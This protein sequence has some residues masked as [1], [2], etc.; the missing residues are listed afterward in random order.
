MTGAV[1]EGEGK[2]ISA[3][4][5]LHRELKRHVEG[6]RRH[7]SPSLR[8][9]AELRRAREGLFDGSPASSRLLALLEASAPMRDRAAMPQ[10]ELDDLMLVAWLV[11]WHRPQVGRDEK[12]QAGF[13]NDL[14]V[15]RS[16]PS[17]PME[18]RAGRRP[19]A[20]DQR[21]DR[22]LS[23]R[24]EDLP[25]EL[26]RLF[27]LLAKAG[28]GG[29]PARVD[30]A[31]LVRDLGQW[32]QPARPVQARWAYQFFVERWDESSGDA[33]ASEPSDATPESEETR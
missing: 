3:R 4:A 22:L 31:A 27:A 1:Q 21:V 12:H 18:N 30:I 24:R 26:R 9:L 13:G 25:R 28:E 29:S 8:I 7:E 14:R 19:S 33:P 10:R 11:A 2:R 16:A 6:A 23:T 20:I 17:D 32:D 15:L 5:V